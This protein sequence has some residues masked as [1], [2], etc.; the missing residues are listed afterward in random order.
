[1]NGSKRG[2]YICLIPREALLLE[3][4]IERQVYRRRRSN[5][6]L[7][8]LQALQSVADAGA[9]QMWANAVVLGLML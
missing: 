5:S 2:A 4:G 7:L 1:M 8:R 3:E 9:Q 6:A